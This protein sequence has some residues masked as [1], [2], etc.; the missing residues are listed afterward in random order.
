MHKHVGDPVRKGEPLFTIYAE[1]LHRLKYAL[2][3]LKQFDGVEFC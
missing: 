3:I 1:N 2:H